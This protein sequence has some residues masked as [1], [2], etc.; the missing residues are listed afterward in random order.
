M[1]SEELDIYGQIEFSPRDAQLTLTQTWTQF[2]HRDARLLQFL[3]EIS[4]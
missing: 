3:V 2:L 4:M 1:L